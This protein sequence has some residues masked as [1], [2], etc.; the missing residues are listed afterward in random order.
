M[1]HR[2]SSLAFTLLAVLS[3]PAKAQQHLQETQSR[4]Q[5]HHTSQTGPQS[6]DQTLTIPF[7]TYRSQDS[8]Q[9]ASIIAVNNRTTTLALFPSDYDEY[10]HYMNPVFSSLIIGPNTYSK[11]MQMDP[12]RAAYII[13]MTQDYSTSSAYVACDQLIWM[14]SYKKLAQTKYSGTDIQRVPVVITAGA[15][16]LATSQT[17]S[18]TKLSQ[19][20]VGAVEMETTAK[21][22]S[23]GSTSASTTRAPTSTTSS[24]SASHTGSVP[25]GAASLGM[26]KWHGIAAA[27][28]ALSL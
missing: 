10:P 1:L 27:L 7:Y 25:G 20:G 17:A 19:T 28:V 24:A 4:T 6:H 15:E 21:G 14:G 22:G 16:K 13:S 12:S 8:S 9:S 5:R 26:D 23:N 3:W 18:A 11:D 2:P